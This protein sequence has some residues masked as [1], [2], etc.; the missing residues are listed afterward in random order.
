MR[1]V[2]A[3]G[4]A[5]AAAG[6]KTRAPQ[7]D[8]ERGPGRRPPIPRRSA[9]ACRCTP[10]RRGGGGDRQGDPGQAIGADQGRGLR[11][12]EPGPP[13]LAGQV[14]GK[15]GQ[16]VAPRP[17]QQARRRRRTP[18]AAAR[19]PGGPGDRA[20]PPAP[21]QRQAGGHGG[22]RERGHPALVGGVDHEGLGD[23]PGGEGEIADPVSQ[24]R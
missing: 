23:P 12:A 7:A 22:H 9:P 6:R 1:T 13:G 18:A 16:D 17:F 14:P 19:R 11:H 24:P 5:P 2:S 20:A 8:E 15:A 4:R 10:H 21:E 3:P